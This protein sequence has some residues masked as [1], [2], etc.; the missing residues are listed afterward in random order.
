MKTHK[1]FLAACLAVLL[2]AGAAG[3]SQAQ[4]ATPRV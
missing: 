1:T 2:G 4:E 3:A